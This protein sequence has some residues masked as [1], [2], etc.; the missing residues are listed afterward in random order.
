MKNILLRLFALFL[1]FGVIMQT[2]LA[3]TKERILLEGVYQGSNIFVQNPHDGHGNYCVTSVEVNGQ[4]KIVPKST[5]FDI[6]LSSLKKGE[7][8]RL[9][10]AHNKDCKPKVLNPHALKAAPGFEICNGFCYEGKY[11]LERKRRKEP[12]TL[13]CG[14]SSPRGLGSCRHTFWKRKYKPNFLYGESCPQKW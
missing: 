3:Q 9:L 2:T 6:D 8:V 11:Y 1:F 12:G 7:A 4:R 10:I 5:A 13:L 14:S